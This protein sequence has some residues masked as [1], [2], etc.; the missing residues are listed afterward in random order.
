VSSK[1]I[2][3]FI[4]LKVLFRCNIHRFQEIGKGGVRHPKI[5][6]GRRHAETP[7]PWR[8]GMKGR[9]IKKVMMH[10]HPNPLPSREREN[11]FESMH[12]FGR[13]KQSRFGYCDTF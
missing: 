5:D 13:Q 4:S 10:P 1:G 9:G 2:D 3:F 6:I 7:L 11:W 12:I 8:E